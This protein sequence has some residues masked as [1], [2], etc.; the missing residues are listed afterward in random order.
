MLGTVEPGVRYLQAGAYRN[1][2]VL[3]D[4]AE[5]LRSIYP[6][7]VADEVR[8]GD[9]YYRLLVGPLTPAETG[10][11][12]LSLEDAGFPDAFLYVPR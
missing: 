5:P 9:V 8:G 1:P 10:V 2:D 6:L 12:R 7:V 11:T 3:A 4:A